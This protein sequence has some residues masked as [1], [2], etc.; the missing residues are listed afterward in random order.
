MLGEQAVELTALAESSPVGRVDHLG[1]RDE[2]L[3]HL[4]SLQI[5]GETA[6][7]A[8]ADNRP[9][10]LANLPDPSHQAQPYLTGLEPWQQQAVACLRE[11][12]GVDG[13][14]IVRAGLTFFLALVA[15]ATAEDGV[16]PTSARGPGNGPGK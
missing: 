10:K 16:A 4:V 15:A 11:R 9:V 6:K 3:V 5:F 1:L 2:R 13:D 8:F 12:L 14:A 7:E